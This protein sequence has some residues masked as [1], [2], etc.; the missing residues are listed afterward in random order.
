MLKITYTNGDVQN[1]NVTG[2][3]FTITLVPSNGKPIKLSPTQKA[4]AF[5]FDL[6]EARN[7]QVASIEI[8]YPDQPESKIKHFRLLDD[9]EKIETGKPTPS[10]IKSLKAMKKEHR[11]TVPTNKKGYKTYWKWTF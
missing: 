5:A 4:E 6:A 3:F 9:R 1:I 2:D 10:Y 7:T 8:F 11:H